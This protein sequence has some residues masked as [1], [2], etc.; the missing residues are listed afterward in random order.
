MFLVS[1]WLLDL[2]RAKHFPAHALLLLLPSHV[3]QHGGQ[4]DVIFIRHPNGHHGLVR[5]ATARNE[6]HRGSL[7]KDGLLGAGVQTFAAYGRR[8]VH[9]ARVQA[10][11][12][13]N[14]KPVGGVRSV[15]LDLKKIKEK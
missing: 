10:R 15:A 11:G 5:V 14:V 13:A 12:A 3:T 9:V 4:R 7:A 8:F 2:D 1:L 6:P